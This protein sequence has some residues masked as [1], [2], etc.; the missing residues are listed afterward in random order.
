MTK[1]TTEQILARVQ[2][3]RLHPAID[4]QTS[5]RIIMRADGANTASV[6]RAEEQLAGAT[7]M[8]STTTS[9]APVA[10]SRVPASSGCSQRSATAVSALW[11]ARS[12]AS[13]LAR[14]GRDRHIA[15][16]VSVWIGRHAYRRRGT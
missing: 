5:S 8:S 15:D 4:Q 16:R 14:N 10:A 13:R 6:D 7:S 12:E 11:L 3:L 2:R 9:A 1:I